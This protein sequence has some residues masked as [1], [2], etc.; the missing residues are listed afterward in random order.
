MKFLK[1]CDQNFLMKVCIVFAKTDFEDT[2]YM[3]QYVTCSDWKISLLSYL[4]WNG[5]ELIINFAFKLAF[6][7]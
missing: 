3:H 2:K 5:V 7:T 1:L 6:F 4:V